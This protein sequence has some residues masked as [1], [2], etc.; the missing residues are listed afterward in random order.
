MLPFDVG[1]PELIL[2]FVVVLIVFGPARIPEL[3]RDFGKMVRDLRKMASDLTSEF[4][5]QLELD[6]PAPSAS[7]ARRV[8][9]KCST[10][11]PL[12]HTFCSQCGGSLG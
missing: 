3:A 9:P 8:C 2:V 11:N 1:I 4:T 5:A 10:P 6:A 7:P 12:E